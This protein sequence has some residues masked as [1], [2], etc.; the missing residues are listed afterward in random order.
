[1]QSFPSGITAISEQTPNK[2]LFINNSL[3]RLL[4]Q[5]APRTPSPGADDTVRVMTDCTGGA[6]NTARALANIRVRCVTQGDETAT[7]TL[8][9]SS[10]LT[11]YRDIDSASYFLDVPDNLIQVRSSKITFENEAAQLVIFMDYTAAHN[12]GQ[13]LRDSAFKTQLVA[14]VS[15]EL[16]TPLTSIVGSLDLLSACVPGEWQ[17]VIQVARDACSIMTYNINDL[18]VHR[19]LIS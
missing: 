12:L 3:E 8:S 6:T 10:F 17:E 15:H 1:M 7:E 16:R 11:A 13:A 19:P 5:L 18:T 4:L 9:F 14:T 2:P